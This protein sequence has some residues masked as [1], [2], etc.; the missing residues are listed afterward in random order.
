MI[1]YNRHCT[2]RI[3]LI[4]YWEKANGMDRMGKYIGYPLPEGAQMLKNNSIMNK[5]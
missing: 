3:W 5:S 2:F 1:C 4:V